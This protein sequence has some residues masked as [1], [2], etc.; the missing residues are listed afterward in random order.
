MRAWAQWSDG[1]GDVK[2][3]VVVGYL[4]QCTAHGHRGAVR[5]VVR[6]VLGAV[7][8]G[9]GAHVE[10]VHVVE[11]EACERAREGEGRR[12]KVREGERRRE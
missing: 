3:T 2:G 10:R 7:G 5:Q 11:G 1:R 12:G 9:R 4:R 8:D 6:Q